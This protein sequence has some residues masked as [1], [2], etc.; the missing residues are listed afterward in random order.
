MMQVMSSTDL[1]SSRVHTH[2]FT[3]E[4]T[5]WFTHKIQTED[6]GSGFGR[7]PAAYLDHNCGDDS[8]GADLSSSTLRSSRAFPPFFRFYRA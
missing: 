5:K 8:L 6:T 7:F 1:L 3:H 2:T 4:Q